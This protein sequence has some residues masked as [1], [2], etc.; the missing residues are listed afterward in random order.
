M[1][2]ERRREREREPARESQAYCER[3]RK[4]GAGEGNKVTHVRSRG[5]RGRGVYEVP[6]FGGLTNLRVEMSVGSGC[7]FG[8]NPNFTNMVKLDEE[9]NYCVQ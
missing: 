4:A 7:G 6:I 9:K 5:D 3:E 8:S 1:H 2:G